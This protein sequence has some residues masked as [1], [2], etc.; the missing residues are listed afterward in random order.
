MN[1]PSAGAGGRRQEDC[2]THQHLLMLMLRLRLRLM[3]RLRLRL[4]LML[5]LF[6]VPFHWSAG[7]IFPF[8]FFLDYST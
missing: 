4:T 8:Y 1:T 2:P 7:S 3:L 5:R 6:T